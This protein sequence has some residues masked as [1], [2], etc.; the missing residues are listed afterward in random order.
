MKVTFIATY[1]QRN[2][3]LCHLPEST[4]S[5]PSPINRSLWHLLT[6]I[7][8]Y[9]PRPP[10][11]PSSRHIPDLPNS[12][13]DLPHVETA[14][15]LFLLP[16]LAFSCFSLS[17]RTSLSQHML[18]QA[19]VV[20]PAKP[21][22]GPATMVAAAARSDLDC[23]SRKGERRNVHHCRTTLPCSADLLPD[24]AMIARSVHR[25]MG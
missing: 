16:P 7:V 4:F 12:V 10:L 6:L 25:R 23:L 21:S 19:E 9:S 15:S 24:V 11:A 20:T 17:L 22:I 13:P 3:T 8:L 2:S 5:S 18:W 1:L 14:I